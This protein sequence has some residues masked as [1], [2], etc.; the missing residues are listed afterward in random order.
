MG[1]ARQYLIITNLRV[2][3]WKMGVLESSHNAF[4][5]EDIASV[6]EEKVVLLGGGLVLNIHGAREIFPYMSSSEITMAISIIRDRI[7]K[8]KNRLQMGTST[9][10]SIP[11]QIKKL[12]EL[13]DQNIFT[14]MEV[15]EKKT[16]LLRKM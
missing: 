13:R 9:H 7:Q 14:E 3:F 6:E 5:Y 11:E 16:E 10:E 2:I 8:T 1:V 4:N 15:Q 12:A